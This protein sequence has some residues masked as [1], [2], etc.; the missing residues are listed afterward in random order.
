LVE[1]AE[2]KILNDATVV[3]TSQMKILNDSYIGDDYFNH[4][5]KKTGDH[6]YLPSLTNSAPIL[7]GFESINFRSKK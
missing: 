5:H 4:T 6:S 3:E 7:Q 2:I 1:T